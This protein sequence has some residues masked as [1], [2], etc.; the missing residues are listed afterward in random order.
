MLFFH[1][2]APAG[3]DNFRMVI[4]PRTQQFLHVRIAFRCGQTVRRLA[5]EILRRRA[6]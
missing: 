6:P 1:L 4:R 5:D 2:N 3:P